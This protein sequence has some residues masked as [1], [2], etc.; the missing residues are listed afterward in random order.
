MVGYF[1]GVNIVNRTLHD[2]LEIPN[3]SLCVEKYFTS[4]CGEEVKLFLIAQFRIHQN[5][6]IKIEKTHLYRVG[7]KLK[8]NIQKYQQESVD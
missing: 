4:E 1:I 7:L 8:K 5:R 3:F 6:W 2:L